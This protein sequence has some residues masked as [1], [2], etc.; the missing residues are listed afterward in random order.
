MKKFKESML[1][2]LTLMIFILSISMPSILIKN[3]ME[4]RKSKVYRGGNIFQET[5]INVEGK[6]DTSYENKLLMVSGG[7]E[8]SREPVTLVDENMAEKENEIIEKTIQVMTALDK[9]IGYP[10]S[11]ESYYKHWYKTEAQLYQY[12]EELFQRYSALV[13]EVTYKKYDGT[14]IQKV[15]ID[16]ETND[17]YKVETSKESGSSVDEKMM[18]FIKNLNQEDYFQI[19]G[20]L[21][22]TEKENIEVI[23]EDGDIY[24]KDSNQEC[25][26][27][28]SQENQ[29]VIMEFYP[30][31]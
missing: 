31:N 13:W 24:V 23:Q 6:N 22:N 26:F 21:R 1:Y 3:G 4:L 17:I 18:E 29:S 25:Y 2:W 12:K 14:V 20:I 28:I 11:I 9:K 10:E 8:M 19:I 15:L 27:R 16:K 7:I 30:Y 5:V